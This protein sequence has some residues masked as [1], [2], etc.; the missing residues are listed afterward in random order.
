MTGPY[1]TEGD[2]A[3]PSNDYPVQYDVEYP[4]RP[5]N[6]LT[7]FFRFFTVI[8]IA[9]VL[10]AVSGAT[11]STGEYTAAV[12]AGGF[13]FGGPFLMILFRKKYPRWWFD[14]NQELARFTSR[15]HLYFSL[16][17]D[18]YPSTDEQQ[19]LRFDIRYPNAETDLMRG[20]PI[21]KW[22]LAIPH[23]IV[24]FFL[25]IGVFV[26]VVIAW[27]AILF[28]GTY[29]RGLFDFVVGVQRWFWRVTAYALLLTTDE[30][31][32]FRLAP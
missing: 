12:A 14:W 23:Y 7:T 16:L 24:L 6:R 11:Y 32:P 5:L 31:P 4:D 28:T 15:V 22:L 1:P 30:Y 26:A 9:I 25:S 17:D 13:L 20:M 27:F 3:P 2:P 18:K 10:A 8:P 19:S 29:P 21:V